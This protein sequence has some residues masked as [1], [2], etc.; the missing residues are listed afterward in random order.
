MIKISIT[1]TDMDRFVITL[2]NL[3]L[4]RQAKILDSIAVANS[5]IPIKTNFSLS[6]LWKIQKSSFSASSN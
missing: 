6:K 1:T 3:A 2:F 4:T 5:E